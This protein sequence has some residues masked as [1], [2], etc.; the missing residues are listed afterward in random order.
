VT[1]FIVSVVSTAVTLLGA[2]LLYAATGAIHFAALTSAL[3][4]PVAG[5]ARPL[6]TVGVVLVLV[7][8]GFK[9][10]AVPLHAWAPVTYDGAP[11]P[12]TAYLSTA[13]KLAGVVAVLLVTVQAFGSRADVAGVALAVLAALTMTVG[14]LVALRQRR[15][16][17]LLA[18]SSIAQAGYILAPLGAFALAGGRTAA[19]VPVVVAA[20]V[21]YTIF[22]VLLELAA[23][24]A[25]IALRGDRDGGEITDYRGAGRRAPWVTGAF[26]LALAGLAGLPPGLAGLFAKVTVVRALLTGGAAWLAVVVALNA[27]IGLAYYVRV[28]ATLFAF[29]P[30]DVAA[31]PA[32]PRLPVAVAVGLAVVTVAG[33]VVGVAP[34]LVLDAAN[35]GR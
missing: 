26:A 2:A 14:N 11:L 30:A 18:W 15:M 13:S 35:L 5:P 20:T 34:Q 6:V 25:V 33:L 28:I 19:V 21:G 27:V 1:F 7:G 23:F 24:G 8:L 4:G 3:A 9:V 17:R 12:V 32:R 16:V 31:A 10:A 29:A 22:F